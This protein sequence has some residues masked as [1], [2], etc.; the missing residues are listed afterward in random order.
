MTPRLVVRGADAALA[1]YQRAFGAKLEER[2]ADDNGHVIHAALSIGPI[3]IALTEEAPK[4][5]NASPL[6]LGGS[7]VIFNLVVD[8]VDALVKRALEAGTEVVFPLADQ[9]YGRREG[10]FKD[11]FGHLWILSSVIEE[12]SPEELRK[13]V[14]GK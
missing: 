6:A 2:Y 5:N 7:P 9:H 12:L 4:W 3:R 11:P 13:R 10:R 1:F 14:A 8:D